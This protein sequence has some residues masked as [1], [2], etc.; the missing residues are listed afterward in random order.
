MIDRKSAGKFSYCSKISEEKMKSDK[1]MNIFRWRIFYLNF[2]FI[3]ENMDD[4]PRKDE[5]EKR[6]E[7]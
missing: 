5:D 1:K 4:D 2:V 3:D 7:K 6:E